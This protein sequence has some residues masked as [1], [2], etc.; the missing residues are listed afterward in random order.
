MTDLHFSVI[1]RFGVCIFV[2]LSLLVINL[3]GVYLFATLQLPHAD[4]QTRILFGSQDGIITALA[5]IFTACMLTVIC[6]GVIYLSTHSMVQTKNFFKLGQFDL[7]VLGQYIVI[8]VLILAISELLMI[9]FDSSPMS[10]LDDIMTPTSFWWL[11]IAIVVVAPIYEE[12]VFRGLIFGVIRADGTPKSSTLTKSDLFAIIIS[13]TL[14]A[15][16]HLQYDGVGMIT[17]FAL[18]VLFCHARLKY[19]LGLAILL[20]FL[21]N[22]VAMISYYYLPLS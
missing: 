5:V 11:I 2:V 6:W 19:G 20:H 10:F 18:G 21:N 8:M 22:A 3:L 14:F 1:Q 12:L 15:L 4:L 13:S 16:V 9:Y 7:K 17:I